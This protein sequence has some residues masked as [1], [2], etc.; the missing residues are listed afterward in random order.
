MG[1]GKETLEVW[2]RGRQEKILALLMQMTAWSYLLPHLSLTPHQTSLT[3]Y[4]LTAESTEPGGRPV[5]ELGLKDLNR[6]IL[7][8]QYSHGESTGMS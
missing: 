1:H 4:H 3:S 5:T 6:P 7:Y 2:E 8:T